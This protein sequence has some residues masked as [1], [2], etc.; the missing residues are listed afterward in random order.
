MDALG[1]R[2]LAC[3]LALTL[4]GMAA[5]CGDNTPPRH[6]VPSI[7]GG[8][9]DGDAR[10]DVAATEMGDSGRPADGGSASDRAD[11]SGSLDDGAADRAVSEPD[12]SSM[13][14]AGDGPADAA[15]GSGGQSGGPGGQSGGSSDGAAGLMG[16]AG[17]ADAAL[18]PTCAITA[19]E[20]GVTH[21]M[22][23][24]VPAT[25]GGDRVSAI[26]AP[27]EVTFEVTTS[28]PDNQIVELTVDDVAA[29]TATT[30]YMAQVSS[31]RARF[32]GVTLPID[33]F[34]EAHARCLGKD[35]LAGLAAPETYQVDTT[36][37]ELTVTEPHSGDFIPPSGLTDGTFQVCG[38]TSSAD[39]VGLD[40]ALGSRSAN[41]CVAAG[42]SPTC[43]AIPATD[44]Q[45]CLAVPCPGDAAFDVVVTLGDI[46]G[47]IQRTVISNV[48]CY[49]TLPSVVIVSPSSDAPTYTDPSKHLLASTAP[50]AFR[51][52]AAA[53]GAQTDVV[54][55]SNRA[56]TMALFVGRKGDATLAVIGAPK[57]TRMAV[58]G[59]RCPAGFLFAVTYAGVTLPESLEAADMSLLTP[60]ELRVDLVDQSSA[61]NSSP[62][63]DLWVDSIAPDLLITAPIDICN[64]YHQSNDVYISSETVTSTARH[65]DLTLTNASSTQN[66][67][68]DT[69]TAMTF[70][71]VVFAQGQTTLSGTVSDDAGNA[72]L[73]QPNPCVV[74]V[75]SAPP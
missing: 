11:G 32:P 23:N 61:K 69:F 19:P 38:G 18:T 54:A 51:D 12:G 13:G 29:P 43:F 64:S 36:A 67:S 70:A 52:N 8:E 58:A 20:L 35:G 14:A 33:G 53:A 59:D 24:G 9:E 10:G 17:P 34:Y 27:Y 37:P 30:V 25:E 74:T 45:G 72:S 26:G 2:T 1:S 50:Q 21:P 62:V 55:C 40:P 68:S 42:G 60:T 16:D 49:S 73:L 5:A 39:A 63:V 47:N 31:G 22:L 71:Y 44:T 7:D 66:F 4:F 6:G 3:A 46:A 48:T 28:I 75:G 15:A 57:V 65:V 41:G 56:G